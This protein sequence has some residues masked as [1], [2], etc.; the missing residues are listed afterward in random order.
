MVGKKLEERG[1]TEVLFE[2]GIIGSDFPHKFPATGNPWR[3]SALKTRECDV[4]LTH[5]VRMPM[6]LK[7][8]PARRTMARPEP[9]SWP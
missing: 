3:R 8:P 5:G 9:P 7:L 6:A 2:I 1:V 4:L